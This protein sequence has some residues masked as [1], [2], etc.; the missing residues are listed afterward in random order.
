MEELRRAE[1]EDRGTTSRAGSAPIG[2]LREGERGPSPHGPPS[3]S[4]KAT[5]RRA[6]GT[7]QHE[8]DGA[9]DLQTGTSRGKRTR[10]VRA[11]GPTHRCVT[12]RQLS[13]LRSRALGSHTPQRFGRRQACRPK[14]R[15]EPGD[16]ADDDRRADPAAPGERR[17][18]DRPVLASRRRS[19]SRSTPSTMPTA[20]PRSASRIASERNCV[21]MLPFVAPS[22]RR[23]PISLRR[24]RTEMTMMFATPTAPTSSATAPRPR[25]R[26]FSAALRV[27]LRDER[28]RG[29]GDVDLVRRLGVRRRG[30]HRVDRGGL[31][32]V[33]DLQVDLGRVPVEVRGTSPPPGSRRGPRSR[34]RA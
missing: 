5:C 22:A 7:K 20:P 19:P 2:C 30:E 24:S 27:G 8:R 17:D 29:L 3:R 33:L 18:D 14:R 26:P 11:S 28:G 9:G 16:R 13:H 25:K 34:S 21:R 1:V 31:D 4:G 15:P 32:V 10:C 6:P 12:S 23:S